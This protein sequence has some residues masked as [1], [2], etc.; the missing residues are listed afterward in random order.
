MDGV[1]VVVFV[2]LTGGVVAFL[3]FV[4]LRPRPSTYEGRIVDKSIT[5]SETYQGSGKVLRLHLQ[6]SRG[7]KFDVKVNYDTYNRAQVG[8]WARNEGNGVELSWTEFP[9]ADG[10]TKNEGAETPSASAPR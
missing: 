10:A 8:M 6:G 1:G 2:V 3:T 5:L 7:E 9:P 4:S